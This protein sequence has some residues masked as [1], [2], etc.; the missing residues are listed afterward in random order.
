MEKNLA[1]ENEK[2]VS[3]RKGSGAKKMDV[4]PEKTGLGGGEPRVAADTKQSF[5]TQE[6]AGKQC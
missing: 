3:S 2:E 6:N 1:R 5:I 4:P